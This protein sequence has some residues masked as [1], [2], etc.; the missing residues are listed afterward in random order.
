MNLD[1]I[2][3]LIHDLSTE[4]VKYKEELKYHLYNKQEG[5]A[6]YFYIAT[7][8]RELIRALNL[9]FDLKIPYTVFG[10]GTKINITGRKVKGLMI[11]N[12]AQAVRI[13]NIKGKVGGGGIGVESATV[14]VESGNNLSKLQDFL[15]TQGFKPLLFS[16]SIHG[17]VGGSLLVDQALQDA[18]LKIKVFEKGEIIEIKF[19]ELKLPLH[20]IISATFRFYSTTLF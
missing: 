6:E 11:K 18:V 2:N 8:Q 15:H 1:N 16:S 17:T 13:T 10:N 7:T 12:R 19:E 9:S 20:T 5:I 4:R 3:L 14:E